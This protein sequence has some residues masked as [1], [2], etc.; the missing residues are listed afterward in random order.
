[1]K[2][3][4]E[5]G[6][7]VNEGRTFAGSVVIEDDRIVK[8]G[9][10]LTDPADRVTDLKGLS[11]APGFIDGHSHNDWFAIKND[12]L[13]YFEPFIRQGIATFVTG[14]CGISEIGFEKDCP[15]IDKMG[16]GLFGFHDTTGQYGTVEELFAAVD[17]SMPCN[18]SVLAGHCSARAA[19]SGS[20]NRKLTEEENAAVKF[21]L[22]GDNEILQL[23]DGDLGDH[24][25]VLAVSLRGENELQVF[26]VHDLEIIAV[27]DDLAVRRGLGKSDRKGLF[28]RLCA[29][30]LRYDPSRGILHAELDPCDR[31]KLLQTSFYDLC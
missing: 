9:T 26:F 27:P 31:A 28:R 4:I 14:N 18:M 16:G 6:R 10:D 17:G 29:F 23:A 19:V 5:H 24:E 13:P 1:M 22:V 7:I 30:C 20:V 3:L 2:T 12:P 25:R 15:N 11:L 21:L 8:V